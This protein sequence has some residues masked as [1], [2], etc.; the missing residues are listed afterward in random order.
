M[1]TDES[2]DYYHILGVTK[3]ADQSEIKKA[4]RGLALKW[5][6]DKNKST[7]A[8]EKF[9][10]IN[11]AYDILSSPEKKEIYDKYGK[12][13]LQRNGIR[14]DQSHIFDMFKN[15]FGQSFP[16]GM[17]EMDTSSHG[18]LEVIEAID[19]VDVYMGKQID[20][21]INRQSM[22]DTCH[23]TGSDDGTVR[24]CTV[25]HGTKMV[26]KITQMGPMCTVQMSPCHQCKGSG[27]NQQEHCCHQC[28]GQ[29]TIQEP[30]R[31]K[32]E[33]PIGVQDG[34]TF[35][36]SGEG[37]IDLMTHNRGDIIVVVK[38]KPHS[39]FIH[40][41]TINGRVQLSPLDLLTRVHVSLAESLCG[42]TKSIPH[43]NGKE[44]LISTYEIVKDGDLYV[45]D[46]E[47]LP[48]RD[49]RKGKL[50]LIFVVDMPTTI[51]S[52]KRETL[53]KT[54]TDQSYTNPETLGNVKMTKVFKK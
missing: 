7:D 46:D 29:R 31:L 1:S 40:N 8:S 50:Y 22:C 32:L 44:V 12:E 26:R 13:G 35:V 25:C 49:Q 9:K 19:L 14:F 47:G 3:T 45:I 6:P 23:G 30:Y 42:F 4:Y 18:N 52:N 16:F 34:E 24:Q 54:L 51:A 10:Q 5:H 21:T 41:V 36:I 20:H 39:Q 48:M 2:C 43:V 33:V 15:F 11:E 28:H 27:M 37:H 53:W 38:F 17:N